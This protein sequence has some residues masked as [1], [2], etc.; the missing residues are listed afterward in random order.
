[1][2][3]LTIVSL[4][5]VS[6]W[7][8]GW[9]WGG[10]AAS[11]E[12]CHELDDI[13]N[14]DA[15]GCYETILKDSLDEAVRAEGYWRLG[16]LNAANS[17]FRNAIANVPDDAATV[18]ARWGRLYVQAHQFGDAETLF[19]EA[20]S[21]EEDNIQGLLGLAELYA[22]RFESRSE[23]ILRRVLELDPA[24]P[25]ALV[26]LA[27]LH[28]EVG[29]VEDA[30]ALLQEILE[31]DPPLGAKL[32]A[33]AVLAAA[34]HIENKLPT[35]WVTRA[36][37]INPAFGDAYAVPA[38][39]YI[40][41]RRYKEAVALLEDGVRVEPRHWNARTELGLNLL[42]L[43]RFPDARHHLEIAYT[44]DPFNAEIVNTLRLLDS[45]KYFDE[46]TFDDLILRVH[47]EETAVL[48]PYIR[49]LVKKTGEE[50]AGRYGFELQR[51][52]V[53][54]LYQH[55]DDFAV[56]T[57]G[58][59]GL[60]IL[61]ATFGDVIVMDGPSAKSSDEFDWYSALWHELAHV[62]TLNATENKV[63]RW[64][65]EGVSVYEEWQ[66]G[67]SAGL[68]LPMHFL[69]ATNDGL[70]L[71]IAELDEGFIRPKF[72]NQIGVSY[73]QAGLVCNFIADTFED[74]LRDVLRAYA[75]GVTTTQAIEQALQISVDEFDERFNADLRTRFGTAL[76]GLDSFQEL[77]GQSR[78]ALGEEN[79]AEALRTADEA[80]AIYPAFI[81][82]GS[83]YLVKAQAMGELGDEAQESVTLQHYW[84]L[85]GRNLGAMHS[86]AQM[87]AEQDQP[88]QAVAVQ[89]TV[90]RAAPLVGEFHAELG[91]QL[92]EIGLH[93]E[94]LQ[95]FKA[96]LALEP[97]DLAVAHYNVAAT[98][99]ELDQGDEAKH[100]LLQSLE[101]APRFKP[102][103]ALLLEMH[104][105]TDL[106]VEKQET[107]Q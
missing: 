24:L 80:I 21:I 51:P 102:A 81:G 17:A 83:P 54:E 76:D 101:I 82:D 87:L 12:R 71:P 15:I 38:H 47:K 103:L 36:L 1:V 10:E 105:Q 61:G 79:W 94:A 89:R 6:S 34:D 77:G 7:A 104:P 46:L 20:L 107:K 44:G 16:D 66:H 64:F 39:F 78:E 53:L 30:R 37:E 95:E 60:G 73:L 75:Q 32:D 9:A 27:R 59:P 14:A 70:L 25:E 5:A 63:S 85:G 2:K 97:H 23:G 29:D 18:L 22:Q 42:R 98:L 4:L 49:E 92:R 26:L 8:W 45:L 100:E 11:I 3:L 19:K 56:R 93:E 40:I 88:S 68:S 84:R 35:Q 13:G 72:E 99:H 41:T 58:L 106:D 69:Q 91:E 31:V 74:G 90:V 43:N 57:A 52:V 86:L 33:Y 96:V 67:P 65:A 62:V 50:M 48:T 28:L 55:H